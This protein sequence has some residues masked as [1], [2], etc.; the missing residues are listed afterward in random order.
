MNIKFI[1]IAL[2]LSSNLLASTYLG[3][4]KA[5]V[6]FTSYMP[7][8]FGYV[9]VS[10]KLSAKQDKLEYIKLFVHRNDIIFPASAFTDIDYPNL[11]SIQLLYS[12][13]DKTK[14]YLYLEYWSGTID[15]PEEPDSVKFIIENDKLVGRIFDEIEKPGTRSIWYETFDKKTGTWKDSTDE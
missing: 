12:P 7:D 5:E 11:S 8:P 2:L 6:T 3:P 4:K 10:A 1:C 13:G 9:K 14:F 15:D